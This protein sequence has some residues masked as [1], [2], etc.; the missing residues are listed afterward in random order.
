MPHLPC[1]DLST[2]AVVAVLCYLSALSTPSMRCFTA[3][4]VCLDTIEHGGYPCPSSF[5]AARTVVR[6][7]AA[8][9]GATSGLL[10]SAPGLVE[11]VTRTCCS[12]RAARKAEHCCHNPASVPVRVAF[13]GITLRHRFCRPGSA[14][15]CENQGHFQFAYE[16]RDG[17]WRPPLFPPQHPVANESP[18]RQ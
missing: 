4:G 18:D 3:F 9:A 10:D 11:S 12:C 17:F 8:A 16:A 6:P 15:F 2:L 5:S 7:R 13:T 1:D 14:T